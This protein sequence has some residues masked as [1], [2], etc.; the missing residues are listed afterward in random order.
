[1]IVPTMIFVM[2]LL[3]VSALALATFTI[4]HYSR[5]QND[6]LA[7]NALLSAEAG[8]EQTLY[9]L[10]QDSDFSGYAS[11]QEFFNDTTQGRGTYQTQV[12]PGSI[13]NEK[14]IIA[15]GRLYR[16]AGDSQPKVTRKVRLTVVGTS[17]N[18]YSVQ[19]GPGGL[20]MGNSATI[21]NG[22]VYV[23]GT[24][25]MNNSSR[26]GSSS[27]PLNVWAAH[28]SCPTSGGSSYPSQCSSG[29]PISIIGTQ[30]EIYGEVR[31]TNQTN[32]SHM[33]NPG[34]IADS[35]A[36]PIG[37]PAY[38]RDAQKAA[39]ATTISGAAASCSG[40]QTRTW[41]ADTKITGNV[42]IANN[43]V[44]T[45][46]GNIWITGT[47]TLSNSSRLKLGNSVT[48]A[49]YIMVDGNSI[50][51]NN[52]SSVLANAGGIGFWF[53]NYYSTASCAPDCA[54]VTGTDLYNSKDL[55]TI[56][57]GNSGLAAG[58]VFFARWTKVTLGQSGSIGAVLGQTVELNNTGN[59]SF[60]TQ[61]SSG[62][63]IWSIKNYT[64]IF[65]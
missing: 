54:D 50:S 62:T 16:R 13:S 4:N 18:T 52:T 6:V 64:Q 61:L 20:V 23:N 47:L 30:A 10:N 9:E 45:V 48:T 38:D 43:C 37:L 59:I 49:P 53:I 40:S 22:N 33:Y 51:L 1:M 5:V 35:E 24:L 46:N 8:A 19:T 55:N 25:T 57:L 41:E 29:Q 21:A 27:N 42:T 7:S 39:V 32:G 63:S 34:L 44:V 15:T 2:I 36:A 26:I 31:A 11:E 60:G 58:S 12:L 28:I 17:P 14:L 56:S 3:T 65:D